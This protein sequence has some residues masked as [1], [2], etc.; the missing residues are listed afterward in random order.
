VGFGVAVAIAVIA[1]KP[2]HLDTQVLLRAFPTL[3]DEPGV[4]RASIP[5]SPPSG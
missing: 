5:G 1:S 2:S 3:H 4:I